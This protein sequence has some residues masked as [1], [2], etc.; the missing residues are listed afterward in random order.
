MKRILIDA[1]KCSGCRLCELT[2]SF[3]H[4]GQFRP[5]VARIKV[6]KEDRFGLDLPVV[7]WHCSPCNAM[8]NCPSNAL[9]RNEQGLIIVNEEKCSGCGECAESCPIGAIKLHSEKNIP[10]ICDQCDGKPLCV[11]KCPTKALEY[12]EAETSQPRLPDEI[13]QDALRRWKMIA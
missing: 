13:I 11:E 5:S 3:A 1:A 12:A 6:V 7:C 2:C 9:E 10:L 4:E 8:E